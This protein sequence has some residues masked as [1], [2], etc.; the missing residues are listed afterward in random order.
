MVNQLVQGF[1]GSF[2]ANRSLWLAT[3]LLIPIAVLA[4]LPTAVRA[5]M[6]LY[7][8]Y[9]LEIAQGKI[10]YR[11]FPVEYPPLALLPIVLPQL[12]KAL[13]E[14][15]FR[16]LYY[17]IFALQNVVMCVIT[18]VI[19]AKMAKQ[20]SKIDSTRTI[21]IFTLLAVLNA[22]AILC[23]FDMLPALLTALAVWFVSIRRPTLAGV[24]IGLGIM[25]KLYPIILLPVLGLYY[26]T[27]RQFVEVS[28]FLGGSVL[29]VGASLLP[30]V[31]IGLGHL[32]VFTQYHQ[33][34]GIQLESIAA[35]LI[36]LAKQVGWVPVDIVLNYGAFHLVTP[37]AEPILKVL[38]LVF[39]SAWTVAVLSCFK[40]FQLERRSNN[41]TVTQTLLI[42]SMLILLTFIV[43]SKVFSPQ[44][45]VWLLPFAPFLRTQ[46]LRI[47]IAICVLTLAIF[48]FFYDSLIEMQ[49]LGVLLLNLRNFATIG[50]T[51]WLIA[52]PFLRSLKKPQAEV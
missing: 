20:Q 43:T 10:P 12:L 4:I 29:A 38:P 1:S 41:A 24:S 26:L 27:R 25:A 19:V 18:G 32:F 37:I 8:N 36:L 6:R 5:D 50:L 51:V 21:A 39:I 17:V 35:G 33:A 9:S 11:D 42:C 28:K 22:L 52:D 2:K 30:F 47:F 15:I 45:L 49:L 44:Y 16:Y 14:Q 40:R 46:Q 3:F 23:R 48:P 34:R 7:Y 31:P 13:P